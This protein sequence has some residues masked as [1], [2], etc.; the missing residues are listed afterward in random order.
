M[1]KAPLTSR[2]M[3]LGLFLLVLAGVMGCDSL[4]INDGDESAGIS[5]RGGYYY[6]VDNETNALLM[7][8]R[9]LNVLRSWDLS[10]LVGDTRFQGITFDGEYLW[11]S[12]AGS[13]DL[14][15][16]VDAS[17]DSLII[18]RSFDAP[19]IGRGTIRDI[20]WDGTYLWAVNSGSETFAI[21]PTLYKLDPADGTILEEHVLP[22]AE[23]RALAAVGANADPYGGG[24]PPGLYVADVDLD[25]IYKFRTD[26]AIFEGAFHAPIPPRGESYVFPVA[27]S[28]DG[29]GF[30]VINSSST[31][32]HLFLLDVDGLVEARVE[33][34]YVTPGPMV[35]ATY[36]VRQARPPRV[37]GVIPNTGTR[38]SLQ[39]VAVTGADFRPGAGLQVSFGADI[40][41]TDIVFINGNRLEVEIDIDAGAAFGTRDVTVTNPD[42]QS[43]VGA[44]MFT[45]LSV[46]PL[47]GFLW[48]C[49][50]DSD[51][52]YKIRIIDTTI[53]QTWSTLGVAPGGSAQ[54][55][56]F[57]GTNIWM[58]VGGTD[59]QLLKLD[60]DG[61]TLSALQS[62]TAP[63]NAAGI[64][65]EL[66]FDGEFLWTANSET[67]QVYKQD[68]TSGAIVD[69]IP[70]PGDEIRGVVWVNGDLYCNDRTLDSV[71]LWNPGSSTWSAVFPTPVPPNGDESNR[72]STGM[73]WDGV[74]FWIANSTFEFDYMFQVSI[75]GTVLR[76]YECPNRGDA[77]PS[78]LAFTQD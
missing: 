20:S 66:T 69:S 38:G 37:D 21:P 52:L 15:Y 24:A 56:T 30:W 36:D 50:P 39:T 63:P 48:L 53:V 49:D 27:I 10:R 18:L 11:L 7:L 13:F 72:Y 8:D 34:P 76:T 14:L 74:N 1:I 2:T 73:C 4:F 32:D 42:G 58:C 46:D 31:G 60:T 3:I 25:S 12:V 64:A 17:T 40:T 5:P 23:P 61:A 41:V 47:A 6:F 43:S 57:D 28:F 65:R 45:I 26:K 67:D 77:Q 71:Y 35:W 54:G 55:L 70:T 78:G 68:T 29:V 9:N 62:F 19:P 59:D 75:D 22:T 44:A 51:S 33:I 16:Q